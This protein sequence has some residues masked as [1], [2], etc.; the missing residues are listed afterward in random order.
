M[1]R[2]FASAVLAGLLVMA[3][4]TGGCQYIRQFW[5]TDTRVSH[6]PAPF[7]LL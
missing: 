6:L 2:A 4:V 1:K 5:G 7:T 3:A